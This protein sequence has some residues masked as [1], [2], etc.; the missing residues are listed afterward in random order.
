MFVVSRQFRMVMS[1]CYRTGMGNIEGGYRLKNVRKR[2]L[3]LLKLV[4]EVIN[5]IEITPVFS[6]S[7]CHLVALI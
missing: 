3:S 4:W 6:P 5:M 7:F 2:K 1:N